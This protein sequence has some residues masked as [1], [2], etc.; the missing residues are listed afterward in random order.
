MIR[1]GRVVHSLSPVIQNRTYPS[2]QKLKMFK[3]ILFMSLIYPLNQMILSKLISITV[4]NG[5]NLYSN[6]TNCVDRDGIKLLLFQVH[7]ITV[8]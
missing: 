5:T 2:L 1:L 3:Q 7:I 6:D 4:S 8:L